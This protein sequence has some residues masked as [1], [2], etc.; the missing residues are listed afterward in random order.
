MNFKS[1]GNSLKACLFL[2]LGQKIDKALVLTFYLFCNFKVSICSL[3]LHKIYVLNSSSTFPISALLTVPVAYLFTLERIWS[4]VFSP[5]FYFPLERWIH[6]STILGN[7]S[8]EISPFP[9]M[10]RISIH[11]SLTAFN[12]RYFKVSWYRCSILALFIL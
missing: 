4:L 5:V 12:K 1:R 11:S 8:L 2:H 9:T 10:L 6:N 3:R 7:G